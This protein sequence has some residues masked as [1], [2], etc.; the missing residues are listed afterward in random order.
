MLAIALLDPDTDTPCQQ[1]RFPRQAMIRIGR[2]PDNDLVLAEPLEVSRYHLELHPQQPTA[3]NDHWQL[4]SYGTNGTFLNGQP[5]TQAWVGD[6]DLLE[7]AQGGPRLRLG[8]RKQP[9][10]HE[11]N[12]PGS[13]FCIH[14]GAPLV[15]PERR[16]RQYQ[17][18]R[19]LGKGGM[20]TTYLAWNRQNGRTL[21]LKEMNADMARLAKAQELFDREARVLKSLSH[22]GIP[23]YDDFFVAEGKKYLVME[24]VVGENLE[25]WVYQ[26]GPVAP[27][28]AIA[29]LLPVC[30][31][32]GYLHG[33]T[34]PL[35]HRDVKPAN[36]MERTRDRQ[37]LLLDFGAVK[38]IGTPAG[39]RIGAA[40]YT[41]PEQERGHPQPQSD[42]FALGATLVFLV[43][44]QPP[45][46][47]Y[48]GQ[49]R[50]FRLE[51]RRVPALPPDLAAVVNR[52]CA[53]RL[54]D[55]YATA[56]DLAQALA[57]WAPT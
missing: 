52:A 53:P 36:L 30:D 43:S 29:W 10:D 40:G 1:W 46:Q 54:G 4:Y 35:V 32:L 24:W 20:G 16:V 6:R 23:R 25:Q 39:T 8:L 48:E 2:A 38:E 33:L 51:A 47:F 50:E 49:G 22:P 28:Q 11:G 56:A 37:I 31:I 12:A 27:A 9:C 57:A 42:L 55:R 34:P 17:I 19:P 3:A 45:E 14:C 26:R 13:L 18:L 7:L 44:G 15:S 5:V 21:V 41:A